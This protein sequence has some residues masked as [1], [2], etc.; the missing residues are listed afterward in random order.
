MFGGFAMYYGRDAVVLN[1][2]GSS[3]SVRL[4]QMLLLCVKGGIPKNELLDNLYG[5]ND[6]KDIANRNKN[7]NN[8]I[9]RLKGQLIS[10]GLPEDDYVEINDGMCSFKSSIPLDLDTKRFEET[11]TLARKLGGVARIQLFSRANEMYSGELIPANLSDMWFFHKSIYFKELYLETIQELEA[12]FLRS[13]DYKNRMLLYSRA[14]AIYPFENW[15]VELIKCNLEMYHYKEA[16][17]I[18]NSTMELYARELGSPPTAEMQGCFEKP[19]LKDE[20]HWK[21][22]GDVKGW[23][24]M[25]KAFLGRKDDIKKAIFGDQ[26]TRGAYY[27]SYPSFVD[28]CR[29]VAR[30]KARNK[31]DAVLMFLTLSR[32]EKDVQKQIDLQSQMQLLKTVIGR[33]LRIEDAFTRYGN[34]HFILMLVKADEESCSAIFRRIEEAYLKNAGKGELRYYAD[35]TRQ[36]DESVF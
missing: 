18:Y 12:E 23:K 30:A 7:L 22:I 9:Y 26:R 29:L 15:Q 4:L 31:F 35:M 8:L 6:K 5:W 21:D 14:V 20:N 2:A 25:D 11:V 16:M 13:R 19:E 36:L 3:K 27:C 32:R 33:L 28:Y 24:N 10:V 34:R 1:K 17:D